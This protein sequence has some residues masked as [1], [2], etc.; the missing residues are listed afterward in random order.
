MQIMKF[1]SINNNSVEAGHEGSGSF[2][3]LKVINDHRQS[4]QLGQSTKKKKKNYN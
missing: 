3:Q 1:G 4:L 2:K